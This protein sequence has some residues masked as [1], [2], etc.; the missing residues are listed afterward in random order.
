M[1]GCCFWDGD[2][3]MVLWVWIWVAGLGCFVGDFGFWVGGAG[4]G[5]WVG[6]FVGDFG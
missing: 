6:C 2:G 5:W 3:L 1:L 4:F